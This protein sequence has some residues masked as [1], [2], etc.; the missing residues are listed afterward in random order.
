MK[1]T[2]YILICIWYSVSLC[3][4]QNYDESTGLRLFKEESYFQAL[5]YLQRAAKQGSLPA[6]NC[7]GQMYGDG[8]GV[9]KNETIML[10]MYNKAIQRN[11]IP[12]MLSLGLYY[13]YDNNQKTFELWKKAADLGAGEGW[14]KVGRCYEI[15]LVG[16]INVDKALDAYLKA[17]DCGSPDAYNYIGRLY[18]GLEDKKKSYE[19]YM[20]A[21]EKSVLYEYALEYLVNTLCSKET[22]YY[23]ENYDEN[24]VKAGEILDAS[25]TYPAKVKELKEKYSQTLWNSSQVIKFARENR[26]R[27]DELLQIRMCPAID[28]SDVETLPS[29]KKVNFVRIPYRQKQEL[30]KNGVFGGSFTISFWMRSLEFGTDDCLFYGYNEYV[31][32]NMNNQSYPIVSMSHGLFTLKIGKEKYQTLS[33]RQFENASKSLFDGR[34]HHVVLTYNKDIKKAEIYMDGYWKGN[35]YCSETNALL[36]TKFVF[37]AGLYDLRIGDLCYF[38]NKALDGEEIRIL[39]TYGYK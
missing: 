33:F 1:K 12:A 23:S 15:G 2:V 28:Y 37:C 22:L 38:K 11:Y 30:G 35:E 3:S 34:W 20:K 6:L 27:Y 18:E 9:E 31:G 7:L 5:P 39:Y 17:V 8:L 26:R 10:N 21:Y 24:V 29:G 13:L 19:A 25:I 14:I 32:S 4:A 36:C 16:D